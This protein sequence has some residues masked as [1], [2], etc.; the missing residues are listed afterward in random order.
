MSSRLRIRRRAKLLL[1]LGGV[2]L[3]EAGAWH[4]A[5]NRDDKQAN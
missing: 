3:P 4:Q 5:G 1:F 2:A